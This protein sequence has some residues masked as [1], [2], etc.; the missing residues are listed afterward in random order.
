MWFVH[1]F[2]YILIKDLNAV[3]FYSSILYVP[4]TK[5]YFIIIII[6]I[7]FTLNFLC[8]ICG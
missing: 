5:Y 4:S 2:G 3:L 7:I 1:F 8:Q 6:I